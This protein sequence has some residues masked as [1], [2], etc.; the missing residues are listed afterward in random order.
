MWLVATAAER[1]GQREWMNAALLDVPQPGRARLERKLKESRSFLAT[2]HELAVA[3]LL[4]GCG[5]TTEYE[6][7]LDGLTPDIV[8]SRNGTLEL[9]V[10]VVG[11]FRADHV[12]SQERGWRALA[13]RVS[14]I[15]WPVGIIVRSPTGGQLIPP[16]GATAKRIA[17]LLRDWL[18]LR[19]GSRGV[20]EF[21]G[22]QFGVVQQLPT[23][24]PTLLAT[25]DPGGWLNADDVLKTIHEKV[26][27]YANLCQ[28]RDLPFVVVLAAEPNAPMNVDLVRSALGGAQSVVFT[29]PAF[30][31][32]DR[33]GPAKMPMRQENIPET[34]GPALSAVAWLA[35][36]TYDPGSLTVLPVPSASRPHGLPVGDKIVLG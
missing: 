8:A 33:V 22:Y 28:Q 36:G 21:E 11:R 32:P 12:R 5:Q 24:S 7:Q 9:V 3:A 27:K 19:R 13:Q 17:T 25:P 14:Q 30:G 31:G 10:E 15:A 6:P 1:A 34:F 4:Q 20:V 29:L 16:D 23:G 18:W 26:R 35:P 2:Y